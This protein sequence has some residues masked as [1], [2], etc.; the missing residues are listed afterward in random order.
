[1]YVL[2]SGD[3]SLAGASFVGCAADNQAVP[4]AP[5]KEGAHTETGDQTVFLCRLFI[6]SVSSA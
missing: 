5:S 2:G 6:S 1:M 3:V 4:P